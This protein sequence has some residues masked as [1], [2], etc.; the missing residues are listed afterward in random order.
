M[1]DN[2]G[3]NLQDYRNLFWKWNVLEYTITKEIPYNLFILF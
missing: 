3:K 2:K 1:K